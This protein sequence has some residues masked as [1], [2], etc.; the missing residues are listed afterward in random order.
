MI[1]VKEKYFCSVYY[2]SKLSDAT[3]D[4]NPGLYITGYLR[5]S[6]IEVFFFNYCFKP[7]LS[8]EKRIFGEFDLRK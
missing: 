7:E 2:H 1:S 8:L 4:P 6:G 5:F 3:F